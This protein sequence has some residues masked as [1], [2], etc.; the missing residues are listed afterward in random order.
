MIY[1]KI[2]ERGSEVLVAACDEELLG[3]KFSSDEL[4][5]H[6]SERFYGG[7]VRKIEEL[8]NIISQ[9]TMANLVGNRVVSKAIEEGLVS[10]AHTL[11]IGGV[12]HAQYVVMFDRK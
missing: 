11:E 10:E 3:K 12:K 6:V 7:E 4:E 5:L 1:T 8:T 9:A 2:H